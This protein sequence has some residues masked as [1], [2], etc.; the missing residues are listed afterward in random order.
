[1]IRN[2]DICNKIRSLFPNIGE[3]GTDM[4]IKFDI[5][6][7]SWVVDLKKDQ[8]HLKTYIDANDVDSCLIGGKCIGLGIEV[9]QLQDNIKKV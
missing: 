7:N 2:G 4:N 3:C 6:L 8:H 1:M 5:D 9:A